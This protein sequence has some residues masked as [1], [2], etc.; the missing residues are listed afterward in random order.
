[1]IIQ[2]DIQTNLNSMYNK[3][4]YYT[5]KNLTIYSSNGQLIAEWINKENYMKQKVGE[6]TI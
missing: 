2:T 4:I 3:N 1:M 5:S 6:D